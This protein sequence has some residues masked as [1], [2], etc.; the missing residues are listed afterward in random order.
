MAR[1]YGYIRQ[2]DDQES[3]NRFLPLGVAESDCRKV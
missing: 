1:F 3:M 2:H